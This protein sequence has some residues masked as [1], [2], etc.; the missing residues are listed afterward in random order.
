MSDQVRTEVWS[1]VPSPFCGIASDD[2]K[3]EVSGVDVRLVENGDVVTSAGFELPIDAL[4]PRVAGSEVCLD[5]AYARAAELISRS[6]CPVFSGFGTDVN[7]TRAALSL[8]DRCRGVFDQKRAEASL[9]NLLVVADSGWMATT[10]GEVKNRVDV[11]VVFGTDI[12]EGFP[13]FFERFL[14]NRETL[15]GQ[16]PGTREVIYIGREPS[17]RAAHAPDGRA[18]WVLP[19]PPESWPDVAAAL[20]AIA[21]GAP[22]QATEIGGVAISDLQKVVDRLKNASYGVVTWAA[23]QLDF[24]HADLTVQQLCQLVVQLN[25]T[26]RGGVLPLGGQNGDRTAAQVCAWQTGYPTRVSFARGFPEYDP[27][28]FGADRLLASGEADLLV[29]V[30]SLSTLPPPVTTVPTIVIGRSGMVCEQEPEVFIPVGTPGIDHCGHN[31]RCDSVVALPLYKLRE[32]GLPSA[33]TVLRGIENV[34]DAL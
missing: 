14:W 12:E 11:L 2:L 17:G 21:R 30:A 26:T 13:R 23:G 7:D 5:E 8:I 24:P 4:E 6:H 25:T 19:C 20:T 32:S 22:L 34:L 18:P 33:Q 28:L 15:F 1:N 31:Y 29:W 9:R 10:L 27:F 3:V 16:D